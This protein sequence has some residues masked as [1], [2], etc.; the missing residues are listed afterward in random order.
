LPPLIETHL[1]QWV[2]YHG[3][4]QLGFGRARAPLEQECRRRGLAE[5]EFIV[6][7]I[8][9]ADLEDPE[10]TGAGDPNGRPP[11]PD[12]PPLPPLI[13]Q[14]LDAFRRDLPELMKTHY[15]Q[16]VIYQGDRRLRFGRSKTELIQECL[17]RGLGR[18]EFVVRRVA[19][20][21]PDDDE[22][23]V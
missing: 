20:E 13:Q 14:A 6:Y 3:D 2:A 18:D 22:R 4:Q 10:W 5:G 23:V 11:E 9:A 16:W 21:P 1:H 15:R 17:Q 19:P 7:H 8:D 12:W